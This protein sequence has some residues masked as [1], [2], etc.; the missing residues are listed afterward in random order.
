MTPYKKRTL[1]TQKQYALNKKLTFIIT[2]KSVVHSFVCQFDC[3]TVIKSTSNQKL[4]KPKGKG[5]QRRIENLANIYDGAFC[6][7]S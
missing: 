1:F 5:M 6:K 7:N 2:M 4:L 3:V